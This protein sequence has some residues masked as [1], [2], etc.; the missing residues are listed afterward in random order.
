[1]QRYNIFYM[2]HKGLRQ[3][4]Y[5][6]AGLVLQTDFTNPEEATDLLPRIAEVLDLFD[7]HAHAEDSFILPAIEKFEPFSANLFAEEHVQDHAL[8][9]RMRALLNMYHHAISSEEKTE[10][11]SAIRLSFTEFLVFN[12]QHMAKEELLLNN[13]LWKH[14]SD[15]ELHCI[16]QQIIAQLPIDAA[17]KYNTWMMRALSNNEIIQWLKGIKNEAPEF[18][19]SN[20]L[21]L[22]QYELPDHRLHLVQENITEGALLA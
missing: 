8:G 20:M 12:L 16:T 18:V 15:Q 7:E 13:L 10:M 19:F 11:G 22:A 9:N 21:Q 5:Q 4:M 14:Y 3:M 2:I 1:M 6:T 17:H